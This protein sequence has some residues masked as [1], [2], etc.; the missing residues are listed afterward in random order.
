MQL[1]DEDINFSL[2]TIACFNSCRQYMTSHM[3]V[4]DWGFWKGGL[5][6]SVCEERQNFCLPRPRVVK[7]HPLNLQS[8]SSTCARTKS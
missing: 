6:Y 7:L 3:S 4:A 2:A 8:I 5:Y 1:G